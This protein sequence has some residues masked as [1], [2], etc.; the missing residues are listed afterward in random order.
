MDKIL[1]WSLV[2]TVTT[3]DRGSVDAFHQAAV[4]AG[5]KDNGAPGPRAQ[6][7]PN[8]YGAFVLDPVGNNIEAYCMAPAPENL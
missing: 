6:I 1:S 3:L 7:H 2:L 5:A 8:Y 4:A